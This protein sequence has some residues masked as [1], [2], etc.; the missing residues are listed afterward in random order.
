MGIAYE[1]RAEFYVGT[2]KNSVRLNEISR[3]RT[4]NQN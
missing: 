1:D 2:L 4:A 3:T